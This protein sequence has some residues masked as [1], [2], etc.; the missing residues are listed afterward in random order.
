MYLKGINWQGVDYIN[1]DQNILQKDVRGWPVSLLSL[2][3]LT[4][5]A[6]VEFT[7]RL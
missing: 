7:Q 1:L 4:T 2:R 5:L 6:V 3:Y